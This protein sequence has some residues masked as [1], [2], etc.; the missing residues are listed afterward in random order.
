MGAY[1]DALDEHD[2]EMHAQIDALQ[3]QLDA[4]TT[5]LTAI[6]VTGEDA[7]MIR[8]LIVLGFKQWSYEDSNG[9]SHRDPC[10]WTLSLGERGE[11]LA[12]TVV[13]HFDGEH[14]RWD[15]CR[16]DYE[17]DDP[18]MPP[19]G[20]FFLMDYTGK[21]WGSEAIAGKWLWDDRESALSAAAVAKGS[22]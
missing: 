15:D 6:G 13:S 11:L 1:S 10:A 7:A 8:E 4:A 3:S 2:R 12:F 17:P 16:A 9:G 20:N 21:K 22:P 18:E 19:H 14:W 5:V